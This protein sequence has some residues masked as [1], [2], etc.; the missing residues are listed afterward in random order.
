MLKKIKVIRAGKATARALLCCVAGLFMP[1]HRQLGS[2]GN[3]NGSMSNGNWFTWCFRLASVVL[4][5]C[6]RFIKLSYLFAPTVSV[7]YRVSNCRNE[8]LKI[9]ANMILFR[10]SRYLVKRVIYCIF[11]SNYG[12]YNQLLIITFP[13]LL[14]IMFSVHFNRAFALVTRPLP[15]Y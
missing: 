10:S 4:Q 8:I 7:I 11:F 13:S 15:Y 9:V 3:G 12:R 6:L 5:G 2:M 14:I 1:L